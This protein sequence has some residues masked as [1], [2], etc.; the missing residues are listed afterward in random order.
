MSKSLSVNSRW[1]NRRTA[2]TFSLLAILTVAA[3]V[4][5]LQTLSRGISYMAPGFA[6][7]A[8]APRTKLAPMNPCSASPVVTTN[9]DSGAGSLRGAILEACVDATITFDM[10]QVVSPIT[11]SSGE[12]VIDK[13][14]TIQGPT[15]AALSIG[16]NLNSRV[17]HVNSGM[18]ASISSLTVNN[19]RAAF[20]GGVYN[21]GTLTIT[22]STINGNASANGANAGGASNGGNGGNG[23]GLYNSGTL[24]VINSTISGNNAGNGGDATGTGL[25]GNGGN[26]GGIY[27]A[28]T[29]LL[30]NDSISENRAGRNG[31]NTNGDETN[32]DVGTPGEGGGLFT[33]TTTAILRNTIIAGNLST[34]YSH[35][36]VPPGGVGQQDNDS[37]GG[38]TVDSSS[39][40][41]LIGAIDGL[42]GIT[43]GDNGNQAGVAGT[44]LNP[45]FGPLT[46]NGGPTATYLPAEF[47][48][49]IDMGSNGLALD[50]NN[51]AL[52]TDQRGTGFP[53]IQ[54]GTVDIGAVETAAA[55]PPPPSADISITKTGPSQVF[56]NTDVSFTITVTNLGPDAATSA[57]FA[58]TLPSSVPGGFPMTFVSFNQDSGPAWNCG[59]PGAS[60]SCSITNLPASTTS[61]FTFTGHV[62]AS[63]LGTE[64]TN[65]ATASSPDD[66]ST[67]NNTASSVMDVVSCLTDQLVTTNA[68]S[69]AGSL[70]QAII[71]AC[72]GS[73]ISF[74]MNQVVSPITLTSGELLINKSLTIAGPG[75]NLLTISGNNASRVFDVDVANPG[76]VTISDLTVSNAMFNGGP[77]G[78]GIGNGGGIFNNGT[79][80]VNVTNCALNN[81]KTTGNGGGIFNNGAGTVNVGSSTLTNNSVPGGGGGVANQSTAPI[82]IFNSTLNG[83]SG[84]VGGGGVN[85]QSTGTVTITNC[86]LSNNSGGTGGG[87][88]NS[89]TGP[90][91]LRNTIVALNTSGTGPDLSG[92][93]T[94]NG[95]NLIGKNDGSTGFTNGVNNDKVGS[96]ASPLN[97]LLAALGNYGGPTQ[98]QALLPGS[99]AIDAANNCVTDVTQC[100]DAN[101]PQLPNDQRGFSRQTGSSVDIGAFESRGFNISATSGTPQSAVFNTAFGAPLVA[102]ASS[103]FG[104]PIVGGQV[105]FTAPGSGPSA[106]SSSHPDQASS[107]G[108]RVMTPP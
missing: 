28:G 15:T 51:A 86:T 82:N 22:N 10:T 102:T 27:N 16:G 100:G 91:K 13:N 81:N 36:H 21:E 33:A 90:I 53:R 19:G 107:S 55:P 47:S 4:L 43:P 46:N 14:L 92:T 48:P 42:S 32:I 60:T 39:A 97:A 61:V 88:R 11:L 18:T 3:S 52:T 65:Q 73:T 78:G 5:N 20:G 62:P 50:Q 58:D 9:A 77:S 101:I 75:A 79:G 6:A 40:F 108:T 64:Y 44:P 57:N 95:N 76:V 67:E 38:G 63:A 84:S 45:L 30:I 59:V 29:L 106:T 70:R 98:T 89:S 2:F 68:N 104:E 8:A 1:I 99:P 7:D 96:I 71:D 49:A 83:N 103:V 87:V 12:L 41:N 80:T 56:A 54:N 93:F 74:D 94:S 31:L 66:A 37:D 23:G 72:N 69:G 105:T 24:N 25:G 35:N 17:F 34:F 85:N 26:G